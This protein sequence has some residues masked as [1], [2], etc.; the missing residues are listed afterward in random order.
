MC[1]AL[2]FTVLCAATSVSHFCHADDKRDAAIQRKIRHTTNLVKS[3]RELRVN[4][5]NDPH[6][7]T[8]HFLAPEGVCFPFDP[9][10]CTYWKGKYHLFYAVQVDGKGSWGHASSIDLVHWIHHPVPLTVGSNDPETAVF[11]G[12]ALS[13]K[14]GVPTMIYH[15]LHSGTCI[16]TSEDDD[17]IHWIKSPANPVIRLPKEGDPEYGR[18][19]VWDTCGWLRDGVYYSIS[20][21]HPDVP[22]ATNGDIAYLFRSHD[23]VNWEYMH[24]FYKSDRRWTPADEDC[25]C[26]DF[27]PLGN[28]HVLMFISHTQGTQYYI[29]RYENDRFHPERHGKMNWPGGPVFAQDSLIDDKGR[30]IMWA[31]ACESRERDTQLTNGWSGVM[32]MPRIL[33]LDND[34]TM[35]IKPP[36]ELT[37]LR[38]NPR[39]TEHLTVP[40]DTDLTLKGIGGDTLELSMNVDLRQTREFGIKVRCSPDGVEETVIIYDVFAGLLK[41]DTSKSSRSKNIFQ[42]FPMPQAAFF[43]REMRT[44][45]DVRVQEAPLKLKTGE[46]LELRV[47]LDHS[48]LEV[49][50]NGRQCVTQRVY[51]SRDDSLAVRL[52]STDSA[53]TVRSLQAW[54]M[55]TAN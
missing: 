27:F 24:P 55:A 33:S 3:A 21:D 7:P 28:K 5:Q 4:Y 20:G 30:R 22:P 31:W 12:G 26:P 47:F 42:P 54:D 49:F 39:I 13:N 16:A 11:A 9:Q 23:L 37:A 46:L 35:L 40:A 25:S 34:G 17:L 2:T 36:E 51:P 53:V 1:N 6:R 10:G 29:G 18:Y 19:H 32:T 43:P 8:W 38:V 48:I 44:A 15:G 14:D 52:F 45:K 50:A 41:I